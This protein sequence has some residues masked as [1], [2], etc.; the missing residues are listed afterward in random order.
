MIL[1]LPRF[2]EAER[3]HWKALEKTLAWLETNPDG[4]LSLEEAARFHELY[5]RAGDGLTRIS[6]FA[7]EGELQRYLA[8]LVS[9]A[10]AEIH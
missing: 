9:R 8:W 4:K 10:Y 3:R 2:V 5:Q 7:A 6:T 1:D